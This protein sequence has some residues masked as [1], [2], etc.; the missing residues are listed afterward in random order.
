MS[1]SWIYNQ[2]LSTTKFIVSVNKSVL[3]CIDFQ[4]F[5]K[6]RDSNYSVVV[7]GQV[8][9]GHQAQRAH[10][11][12]RSHRLH[13]IRQHSQ[14]SHLFPGLFI[15]SNDSFSSWCWRHAWLVGWRDLALL[16]IFADQV[17][18]KESNSKKL[19]ICFWKFQIPSFYFK[20]QSP[21]RKSDFLL[22]I[23]LLKWANWFLT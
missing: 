22:C 5:W 4:A 23:M 1:K 3:V 17:Y 21:K 19:N 13:H 6:G 10:V 11:P 2:F 8:A 12:A 20:E 18:F 16:A 9:G 7:A 15:K 14:P